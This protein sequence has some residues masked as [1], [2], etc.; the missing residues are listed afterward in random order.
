MKFELQQVNSQ[1]LMLYVRLSLALILAVHIKSS[2][3][4]LAYDFK[5]LALIVVLAT[6]SSTQV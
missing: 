1:L 4:I 5:S 2:T 3:L 6:V